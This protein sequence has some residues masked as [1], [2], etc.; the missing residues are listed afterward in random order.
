PSA[1]DFL[2]LGALIAVFV[3]LKH[4]ENIK[5]ILAGTENRI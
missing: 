1:K 3:I 4:K 2:I 5:R